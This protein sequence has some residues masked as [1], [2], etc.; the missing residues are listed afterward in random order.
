ML[1]RGDANDRAGPDS[2][3]LHGMGDVRLQGRMHTGET[4]YRGTGEKGFPL[5]VGLLVKRQ[6]LTRPDC[7]F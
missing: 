2:G 6:L 4:C 7:V 1:R 3:R 5:R